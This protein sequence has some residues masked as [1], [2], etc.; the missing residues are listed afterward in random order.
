MHV[1]ETEYVEY[2]QNTLQTDP[3]DE[4]LL[5]STN[6]VIM[7]RDRILTVIRARGP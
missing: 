6:I 2:G 3:D 4:F 1:V 5:R 7:V